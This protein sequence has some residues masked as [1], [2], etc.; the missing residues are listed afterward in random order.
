[1]GGI[2]DIRIG[3]S[4]YAYI[5][6]SEGNVVMHPHR[7]KILQNYM[8]NPAVRLALEK[9]DGVTDFINDE[10]IFILAA[11][12]RIKTT[13]WGVVV[14]Q[15]VS[16]SYAYAKEMIQLLTV[17]FLVSLFCALGL[18]IILAWQLSKPV[19]ALAE[20]A[21]KVAEGQMDVQIP[22]KRQDEIGELAAAF[23]EMTK[24]LKLQMEESERAHGQVLQSQKQL[25]QS[26]K[27][28]GIGQLAAG[29]AH[30]I[31]NPLN[32]ISGFTE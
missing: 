6:D 32:V 14:R 15:P 27:M 10:D 29:L 5:V 24:K 16:E 3:K 25:A 13:G 4:G 23:N 17:V 7:E 19:T 22:V 30:E 9:G 11:F 20:G 8:A 18:G 31:Y 21:K 1:M 2:D 28:A 12:S 26:E